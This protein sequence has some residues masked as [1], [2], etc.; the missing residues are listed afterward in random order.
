MFSSQAATSNDFPI[1]IMFEGSCSE[2]TVPN[3][4]SINT[5]I[6]GSSFEGSMYCAQYQRIAHVL[7]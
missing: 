6:E 2:A 1:H 3:D 7:Y 4:I 5:S